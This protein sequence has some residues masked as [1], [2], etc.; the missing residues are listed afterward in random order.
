MSTT[1]K[2]TTLTIGIFFIALTVA[3][4]LYAVALINWTLITPVVF[5]LC[6]LWL[7][8]LGVIRTSQPTRYERSGFSTITLGLIAIA[9]GSAWFVATINWIYS[10]AIILIVIAAIAIAAALQH[11]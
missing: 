9:A 10:I 7:L 5:V 4:L 1:H 8:I 3:I 6:G 11:K 2:Q